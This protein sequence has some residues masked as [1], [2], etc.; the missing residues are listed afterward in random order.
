MKAMFLVTGLILGAMFANEKLS[1]LPQ[2]EEN[3]TEIVYGHRV[4]PD[5]NPILVTSR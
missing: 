5:G 1:T 2:V 3:K 4:G